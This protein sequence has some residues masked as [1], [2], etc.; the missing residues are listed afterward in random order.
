MTVTISDKTARAAMS[1]LQ[2]SIQQKHRR[3][4]LDGAPSRRL[5]PTGCAYIVI[6]MSSTLTGTALGVCDAS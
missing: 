1:A 4:A 6:S 2:C 3:D 5:Y